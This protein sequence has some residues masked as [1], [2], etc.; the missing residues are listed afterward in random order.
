MIIYSVIYNRFDGKIYDLVDGLDKAHQIGQDWKV[1]FSIDPAD[2]QE[3]KLFLNLSSKYPE[4][5]HYN[6]EDETYILERHLSNYKYM[7]SL[8]VEPSIWVHLRKDFVVGEGLIR[9]M[10]NLSTGVIFYR[11]N[12]GIVFNQ[13]V[14]VEWFNKK[15]A[16]QMFLSYNMNGP[17]VACDLY[18]QGDILKN[19]TDK[20][21]FL[22]VDCSTPDCLMKHHLYDLF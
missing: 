11:K 10:K 3:I 6:I 20:S 18:I 5:I 1:V 14:A 9:Q 8:K 2:F 13:S 19:H 4:R 21:S 17:L 15:I 7:R 12:E 22:Q 16:Y